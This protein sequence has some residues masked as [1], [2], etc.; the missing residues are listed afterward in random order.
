MVVASIEKRTRNGRLRYYVRYR[1]PS[2]R[3]IVKV[4][5]RK[6]DADRYLISIENAKITGSYIDP[7]RAA[8]TL[9]QWSREWL[10]AQNHLK[11]S[12]RARS[13]RYA[14]RSSRVLRETFEPGGEPDFAYNF[15][16]AVSESLDAL[17]REVFAIHFAPS[18]HPAEMPVRQKSDGKVRG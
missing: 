7:R 15:A 18:A 9:G 1:D 13:P 17:V 2:E 4:F 6:I 10:A 16:P 11:P 12:T 5:N 8:L 14:A 3:Q